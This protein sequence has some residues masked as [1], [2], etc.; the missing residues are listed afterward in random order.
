MH[1]NDTMQELLSLSERF[2]IQLTFSRPD[3]ATYLDIIHNL[4]QKCGI[5]YDM[6]KLDAE[7]EKFALARGTRSARAAKQFIDGIVAGNIADIH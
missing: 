5:K 3:K 1:F 7:A 4:A 6:Q 2:G